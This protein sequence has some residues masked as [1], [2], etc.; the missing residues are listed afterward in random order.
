MRKIWHHIQSTNILRSQ[1]PRH[2]C[3]DR[4]LPV[5]V[6]SEPST[7]RDLVSPDDLNDFDSS[8]SHNRKQRSLILSQIYDL[9]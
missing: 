2:C 8:T 1:S 4:T 3:Y 7:N 5:W 6:G 9:N